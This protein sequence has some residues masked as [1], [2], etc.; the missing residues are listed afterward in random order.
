MLL[1]GFVVV[2]VVV[3]YNTSCARY[4]DNH[5]GTL[6]VDDDDDDD[7]IYIVNFIKIY[8]APPYYLLHARR[9]HGIIKL[10][11]RLIQWPSKPSGGKV[12]RNLIRKQL[13]Q[14]SA[15]NK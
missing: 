4:N 15:V 13:T 9:V 3:M 11:F 14:D 10:K 2:V 6:D 5:C 12:K 7:C 1:F 8:Q